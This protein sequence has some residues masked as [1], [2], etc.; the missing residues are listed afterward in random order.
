[1][2][3]ADLE[4]DLGS[5][6]RKPTTFNMWLEGADPEKAELVLSYLRDADVRP[7]PLVQ[8]LRKNGIPVTMETVRSYR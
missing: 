1:M 8:K 7:H 4:A 5:I 2:S 3:I 6:Q